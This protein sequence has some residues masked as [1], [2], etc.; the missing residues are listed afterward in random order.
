MRLQHRI[1]PRQRRT[2][3]RQRCSVFV[4]A[5]RPAEQLT[6]VRVQHVGVTVLRRSEIRI[7]RRRGIQQ[8]QVAEI[9]GGLVTRPGI[10]RGRCVQTVR[11]AERADAV[12]EVGCDV[13]AG[14]C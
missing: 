9:V 1:L 13:G 5:H 2:L 14:R 11:L 8:I 10:H 3:I 12:V 6:I 7:R 4:R